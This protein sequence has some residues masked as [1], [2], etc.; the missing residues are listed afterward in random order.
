VGS[1]GNYHWVCSGLATLLVVGG[2]GCNGR[3]E[4]A[5]IA[6][7]PD[8]AGSAGS[9]SPDAGTSQDAGTVNDCST[10]APP[11]LGAP[12]IYETTHGFSGGCGEAFAD[13]HGDIALRWADFSSP[14]Y[15]WQLITPGGTLAAKVGGWVGT[16]LIPQTDGFVFGPVAG[17]DF[18]FQLGLIDVRGK[19]IGPETPAVGYGRVAVAPGGGFVIVGSLSAALGSPASK[20]WA[21]NS[22]TTVR[23]KSD[24]DAVTAGVD[25][26]GNTLLL[27]SDGSGQWIASDGT[28]I[29][30]RFALD[31]ADW[32]FTELD[33]LPL[34]GGGIAVQRYDFSLRPAVRRWVAL[35]FPGESVARAVPGWLAAKQD[36]RLW[37]G[38]GGRATVVLPRAGTLDIC[39]QSV[40]IL[41][42]N[43]ERCGSYQLSLSSSSCTSR[44]VQLGLDGT[45]IQQLPS[46]LER[47]V[48][49][50]STCTLR[51]W[52]ALLR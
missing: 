46:A 38:L 5:S 36:L 7:Q 17:S 22:D 31:T 24:L 16:L 6:S 29:G 26:D 23:W 4:V 40:E 44:D 41:A 20:V 48:G 13:G 49:T 1:R 12:R 32:R 52:P 35:A 50:G 18:L 2:G 11:A 3:A 21:F 43:G 51:Y 9:Q 33:L 19:K 10:L 47:A 34:G 28:P 8:D 14:A 39:S 42:P 27:L 30:A 37:V 15:T 45:L 25:V